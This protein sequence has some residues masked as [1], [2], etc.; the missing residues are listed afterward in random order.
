MKDSTEQ[1]KK[2]DYDKIQPIVE[3]YACLQCEGK[4]TG[5][6]HLLIRTTGC[7][8]RCQF[9]ETDFCDSWYTS[10]H[11]SKGKWSL[12][13]IIQF[14]KDHPNIKHTMITGGS[15]TMHPD[16]LKDLCHIAKSY[17]HTI[18][19]ETEGS[20]Y[21]ETQ[22]D[23]IS[24]SPKFGNSLPKVGSKTPN[25]REVTEKDVKLHE[26]SRQNYDAM[27]KLIENHP[28][29]Q[30]KPVISSEA[31]IDEL[32]YIQAELDIP[33]NMC[34]LMPAGGTADELAKHRVWLME[35]CW[36]NGYNYTDRIH[37]VAY[38]DKRGV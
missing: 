21:V 35:Y 15:P 7:V 4:L 1:S 6:P 14:F 20:K 16:L 25:D 8:L 13:A 22:A 9:S 30:L 12:N 24:L 27:R 34:W 38:N 28:D 18:T 17:G 32:K 37:I 33:N 3:V 10:W 11:P 2:T 19:I 31:E 36:Q 5:V 23:L 29:Y 26:K